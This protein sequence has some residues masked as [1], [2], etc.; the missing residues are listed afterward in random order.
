MNENKEVGGN[1][2]LTKTERDLKDLNYERSGLET[3]R[4]WRFLPESEKPSVVEK[5]REKQ[6]R[7]LSWLAELMQNASYAA[8]YQATWGDLVQAE[9]ATEAALA[10]ARC[11][12]DSAERDLEEVM[13]RAVTLSDGTIV[14]RDT[15]G[16]VRTADGDVVDG[17]ELDTI[18]W[19]DDAPTYQEYRVRKRAVEEAR[20][21]LD[22]L[23]RYQ[24]DVLGSA[25][26]RLSNEDDP[27]TK[28]ELEEIKR[29][30][31]ERMPESVQAK[32]E[33]APHPEHAAASPSRV[34]VPDLG[35]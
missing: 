18:I 26:D 8:L 14:F 4:M 3:G 29:D 1:N 13:D 32:M 15:D 35:S 21:L 7:H 9:T 24:T 23:R 33:P 6:R 20:G 22:D 11:A 12:L 10:D 5:C 27:P 16:T 31:Q 2:S 19:R 34:K 25:R 28:E 30:I 17:A